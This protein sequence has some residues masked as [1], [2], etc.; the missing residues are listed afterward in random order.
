[1]ELERG[2]QQAA[3][4]HAGV[5]GQEADGCLFWGQGMVE[6]DDMCAFTHICN[7]PTDKRTRRPRDELDAG[8]EEEGR[9][10]EAREEDGAHGDLPAVA[11][12]VELI[13]GVV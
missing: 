3:E 6:L 4:V 9:G 13:D 8:E 5:H 7:Q 10:E 11:P 2:L 1:V 12:G